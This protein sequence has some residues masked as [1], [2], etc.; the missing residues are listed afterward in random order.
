MMNKARGYL[1]ARVD[2]RSKTVM[3]TFSL[4][5]KITLFPIG[6]LDK[7]T[8]GLLIITDDGALCQR[9]TSPESKIPKTYAFIALGE[10]TDERASEIERGVKIYANR[11][12]IT[13]RAKVSIECRKTVSDF[14]EFLSEE[15]KRLAKRKPTL[16]AVYG[17]VEIT[18]GK[19]HQVRRM[20]GSA[21]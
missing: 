16:P 17:T 15:D 3:D 4:D 13:S 14:F 9:L 6:R 21:G 2:A 19:K 10:I 12:F 7:D 18:E 20:I 5:D 11:D 8:E 1:T